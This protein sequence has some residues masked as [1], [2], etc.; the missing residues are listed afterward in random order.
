MIVQYSWNKKVWWWKETMGNLQHNTAR[1][2]SG[3]PD[4]KPD[5]LSMGASSQHL[6]RFL[7]EKICDNVL[8]ATAS[9]TQGLLK[10]TIFTLSEMLLVPILFYSTAQSYHL[11]TQIS[12]FYKETLSFFVLAI[13][14]ILIFFFFIL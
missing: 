10:E 5:M 8:V 6:L 11:V 14:T 4:Q 1:S 3:Q 7:S 2:S 13:S 9:N 12:C